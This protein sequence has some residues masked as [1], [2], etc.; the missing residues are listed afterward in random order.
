MSSTRTIRRRRTGAL[1]LGTAA[2]LVYGAP[3]PTGAQTGG[4]TGQL[5]CVEESIGARDAAVHPEISGAPANEQLL[6]FI[7]YRYTPDEGD[8]VQID[9]YPVDI[10]AN[11]N[12]ASPALP[13]EPPVRWDWVVYR[14]TNG[15]RR[16]D[17]DQDDNIFRGV[18][19]VTTCPQTVRM[20]PK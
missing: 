20:T 2:V 8:T 14:D 9:G 19:T 4:A 18:A 7:I 12:G 15:N 16:W 6:Q 13:A 17:I 3:A 5:V 11:G 10:D 1:A